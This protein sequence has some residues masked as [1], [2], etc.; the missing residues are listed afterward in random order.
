VSGKVEFAVH[1]EVRA[2]DYERSW[3]PLAV[4]AEATQQHTRTDV[5]I[6]A[7]DRACRAL[8]M[9][10]RVQKR[11]TNGAVAACDARGE[12][13]LNECMKVSAAPFRRG[14]GDGERRSHAPAPPPPRTR[15]PFHTFVLLALPSSCGHRGCSWWRSARTARRSAAYP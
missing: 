12:R 13:V 15:R 6:A 9:D 10:A 7:A 4:R 8:R 11:T 5:P 14:G 3:F 1:P 2:C